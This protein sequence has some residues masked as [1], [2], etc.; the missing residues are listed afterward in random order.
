ME[1]KELAP[2]LWRWTAPHPDWTPD[3][4]KPGGW[5]QSVGCLH[6]ECAEGIVLIDPLAPPEGSEE[7]RRFWKALDDDVA[8]VGKPV[9][10]LLGNHYHQRSAQAILE[11]YRSGPGAVILAPEEARPLLTCE[12]TRTFRAGDRLPGGIMA[13]AVSGLDCPGETVFLLP[14]VRALVCADALI[15]AGRGRVRVPPPSWGRTTPE[16]QEHYRKEFRASLRLLSDLDF[17]KILTSHGEPVLAGGRQSL[18]EALGSPDW[19]SD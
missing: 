4:D 1:T 18:A 17:E 10:I 6:L 19:G 3:K 7:S 8:R 11:R 14:E 9:S 13:F 15:G 5:A 12:V 16:G 2:G